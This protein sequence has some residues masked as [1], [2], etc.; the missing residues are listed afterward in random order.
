MIVGKL[1]ESACSALKQSF[2]H[3]GFLCAGYTPTEFA[4]ACAAYTAE[5][6]ALRSFSEY[7]PPPGVQW[8]DERY[9]GDAYGAFA[10]AAYVAE[11]SFDMT[12]YEISV[13]DIVSRQEVGRVIHPGL[14]RGQ[15]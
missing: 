12:T 10:W 4:P 14:S 1:V 3:S 5:F 9:Q 13:D 11:V 2:V 8:D 6:G 15:V 7:E